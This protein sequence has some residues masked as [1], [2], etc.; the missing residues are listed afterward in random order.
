MK[1]TFKYIN[2]DNRENADYEAY[3][4]LLLEAVYLCDT[5]MFVDEDMEEAA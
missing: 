4:S 2:S 3:I 5:E 1:R